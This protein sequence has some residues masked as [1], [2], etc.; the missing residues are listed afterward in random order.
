[1]LIPKASQRLNA[2]EREFSRFSAF[3]SSQ[4]LGSTLHVPADR[5]SI[6]RI[7]A[8]DRF[9]RGAR[10]RAGF[11]YQDKCAALGALWALTSGRLAG[12]DVEL[13]TDLVIHST[14][15]SAEYVSIKGREPDQRGDTGWSWTA[16]NKADLL[17]D[18]Y[19]H[20]AAGGR[21]GSATVWTNAGLEG[22]ATDLR[23]KYQD[24]ALVPEDLA[25][26]VAES[27]KATE[28][29]AQ[30]F[31][32]HFHWPLRKMPSHH[33]I[34]AVL[35][36]EA[37]KILKNLSLEADRAIDAVDAL[38][39]LI[40]HRSTTD[41]RVVP[42][43]TV[44]D[45]YHASDRDLRQLRHIAADEF[46]TAMK[47]AAP[48]ASDVPLHQVRQLVIDELIGR[49]D[50]LD[51]LASW[52]M[53]DARPIAV[54]QG[55][56]GA[57][58][59][60]VAL[61]F[62]ARSNADRV[63]VE[64]AAS[65]EQARSV[66]QALATSANSLT[67]N[68]L[69]VIDGVTDE[70][71]LHRCLA[72]S[73]PCRTI[74]TSTC[75]TPPS[76]R[77]IAIDVEE[78][79]DSH[80]REL[81]TQLLGPRQG[82]SDVVDIL[83][84]NPLALTQAA[85][86]C[87]LEQI[88]PGTYLQRYGQQIA[89]ALNLGPSIDPLFGLGITPT[90]RLR[91][92]SALELHLNELERRAPDDLELLRLIACCGHGAFHRERLTSSTVMVL[93]GNDVLTV[94]Y[95][96]DESADITPYSDDDLAARLHRLRQ[97]SL[98]S[99]RG[100]DVQMHEA[101]RRIVLDRIENAR[102]Y[103]QLLFGSFAR[104]SREAPNGD[105][106]GYFPMSMR[107]AREAARIVAQA[108]EM[109]LLGPAVYLLA[110]NAA[111]FL[112]A[113][114]QHDDAER[115]ATLAQEWLIRIA[116]QLPPV[117]YAAYTHLLCA[118]QLGSGREDEAVDGLIWLSTTPSTAEYVAWGAEALTA[119]ATS[120]A[121]DDLIDIANEVVPPLDL[122]LTQLSAPA[123]ANYRV[124]QARLLWFNGKI[125]EAL[126]ALD[127]ATERLDRE[128]PEMSTAAIDHFWIFLARHLPVSERI[129]RRRIAEPP[130]AR[131]R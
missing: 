57:G 123:A 34:S 112:Q 62:A 16:I 3:T 68:D 86:V 76:Q 90:P 49:N 99:L 94:N 24:P 26:K 88:D 27:I 41:E 109:N 120:G 73:L 128:A 28:Y 97:Q 122:N 9:Q 43:V 39:E 14:D 45:Q 115:L 15:G 21:R 113:Q 121:H 42:H 85:A 61:A 105:Q 75:T 87:S 118:W 124:A 107:T 48:L 102:P 93:N 11:A 125:T 40:A 91:L 2:D 98:V 5:F 1:M 67:S 53:D 64:D 59:T 89:K 100:S 96:P 13:A 74:V 7:P 131:H 36:S 77:A 79:S 47:D 126:E 119:L 81:L 60:S 101:H 17:K 78:L 44:K 18:L 25:K 23:V 35:E 72:Q 84:G 69:V 8:V 92:T 63:F 46:V 83:G 31:L 80:A 130:K 54:V 110:L 55:P 30:Q 116:D 114:G 111:P 103:F 66:L 106:I 19:D 52:W 4:R 37:R 95:L 10:S 20:W 82:L 117:E 70:Q 12:I 56:V 33:D 127:Q 38:L 29:D 71:I 51:S 58:K 104:L 6:G 32:L 108:Q 22:P 65:T 50:A 129:A